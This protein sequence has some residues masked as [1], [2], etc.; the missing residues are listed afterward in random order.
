MRE[1]GSFLKKRIHE[2]EIRAPFKGKII[3]D[4][5]L[6]EKSFVKE[7]NFLFTLASEDSLVEMLI[8]EGDYSRIELGAHA[9]VKFYAFPEKTYEGLVTGFKP[10]AEPLP[11]SG[12]TRHAVK[13][14]I[15]LNSIPSHIQNGMSAKV[16]LE[17]KPQSFL[18]RFY[19]ETF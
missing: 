5:G 12:I 7:G 13:V 6:R 15:R 19:H 18:R 2:G 8:Q 16:T 14:L 1:R 11:K 9:R 3:S 17:V 4:I 10:F